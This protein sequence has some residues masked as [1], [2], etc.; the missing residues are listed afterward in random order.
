MK[1]P[2]SVAEIMS[3]AENLRE[4]F[5]E[6]FEQSDKFHIAFRAGFRAAEFRTR[7]HIESG[8]R[9]PTPS[10]TDAEITHIGEKALYEPV[11]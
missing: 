6:V 9:G 8:R 7:E 11:E 1:K 5:E 2:K 3:T 4:A 10:A